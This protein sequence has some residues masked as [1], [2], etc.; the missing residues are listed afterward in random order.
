MLPDLRPHQKMK[1]FAR[2]IYTIQDLL[3]NTP[4]AIMDYLDISCE[5]T[6]KLFS[7]AATLFS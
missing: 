3:E 4:E 1:L 6:D 2:A 5:V 7:D